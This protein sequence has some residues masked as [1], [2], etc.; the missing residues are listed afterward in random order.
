MKL[1]GVCIASS[2]AFVGV[3]YRVDCQDFWWGTKGTN[4]IGKT[5]ITVSGRECQRWSANY[6][7]E[8]SQ[9]VPS[10]SEDRTYGHCRNP[11]KELANYFNQKSLKG[12]FLKFIKFVNSEF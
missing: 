5:S 7:H 10:G 3:S 11:G 2:A 1:I 6:P 9:T 12:Q 4:Y 8:H